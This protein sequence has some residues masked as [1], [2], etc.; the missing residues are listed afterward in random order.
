MRSCL[1]DLFRIAANQV[2]GLAGQQID[3]VCLCVGIGA[4]QLHF[5]RS[6]VN[7]LCLDS[8]IHAALQRR[9][10]ARWLHIAA[11]EPMQREL[12]L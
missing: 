4:D 3:A 7:I 2:I 5:Y 12:G 11:V 8:E 1:V 9:L 10:R 6:P